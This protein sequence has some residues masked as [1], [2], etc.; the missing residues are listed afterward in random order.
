MGSFIGHA[1][2]G[3]FFFLFGAWWIIAVLYRYHKS[4]SKTSV[5]LFRSS[6]A[7]SAV[8]CA[9]GR[10][11]IESILGITA[12]L[13][14]I[15][16]EIVAACILRGQPIGIGNI[17]HATMYFF[18][19][20]A[21]VSNLLGPL[22]R[23]HFGETDKMQYILLASAMLAEGILFKFHLYGRSALDITVHTLLLYA[24]WLSAAVT[25]GEMVY[26]DN[27]L[28]ALGRGFFTVLQG[29]WFWQTGFVLY[30]PLPGRPWDPDNH[31][32][33][34]L[35]ACFFTWH[36]GVILCSVVAISF[37]VAKFVNRPHQNDIL[38]QDISLQESEQ[39]ASLLN[40]DD[41]D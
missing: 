32:Q 1:I 7:F 30:N 15:F 36:V 33:L 26:R 21:S 22:F 38:V 9:C 39:R 37:V 16:V 17:Q 34:M 11:H 27:V 10:I 4:R 40:D 2:P 29:T 35:L 23:R 6:P 20:L 31:H 18:F 12:T 3:S 14:G 19:G 13:I 24:V 8:Q 28:L 5:Q 41:F 25:F